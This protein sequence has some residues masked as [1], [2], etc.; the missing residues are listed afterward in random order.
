MLTAMAVR[1]VGLPI[2]AGRLLKI[3]TGSVAILEWKREHRVIDLWND[4][5]HLRDAIAD[6]D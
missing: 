5:S 6:R 3:S 2:E 4:R 1:W